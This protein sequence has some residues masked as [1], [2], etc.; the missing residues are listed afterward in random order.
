MNSFEIGIPTLNRYD[1]LKPS[2]EKY[3]NDFAGVK[4]HVVDNGDQNIEWDTVYN[5]KKNIGVAASWNLICDEIFRTKE[6]AVIVNDDVYLGYDSA[7]IE[8]SIQN[9]L[10]ECKEDQ[11]FIRSSHSWSVFIISKAL[12]KRIGKFD[13][14]FWPAYYE[15]SDYIYRMILAETRQIIDETISPRIYNISGSYDR[16]PELVNFAMQINKH[17]YTLKWGGLPLLE[18]YKTP[19]GQ[20]N[21]SDFIRFKNRKHNIFQFQD[22]GQVVRMTDENKANPFFFM[23]MFPSDK[24]GFDAVDPSGGPYLAVDT[25]IRA[26][27]GDE[28]ER[29]VKRICVYPDFV[30][31]EIFNT[32]QSDDGKLFT[33][34]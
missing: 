31:F 30:I 16:N 29:I 19:F 2:L 14:L 18:K 25:D 27:F 22:L 8:A 6:Y 15:D 10:Q 34:A 9:A 32:F 12:Y 28:K 4:I 33:F 13:E 17:R 3:K 24:G 21:V 7:T 26:L 20:S 5:F 11:I 1:L 23:R